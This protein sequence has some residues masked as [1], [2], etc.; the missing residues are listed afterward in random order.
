MY[1]PGVD[2][3]LELPAHRQLVQVDLFQPVNLLAPGIHQAH[4]R[5]ILGL[6][7]VLIQRLEPFPEEF[8]AAL[9]DLTVAGDAGRVVAQAAAADAC[10]HP[11]RSGVVVLGVALLGQH[12]V[13]RGVE[14]GGVEEGAGGHEVGV[15]IGRHPRPP[16][17][18]HRESAVISWFSHCQLSFSWCKDTKYFRNGKKIVCW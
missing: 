17:G 8:I 5:E 1:L 10:R 16:A 7:L 15:D 14:G 18:R 11:F 6:G 4:P 13:G 12:H 3:R 9:R 2:L